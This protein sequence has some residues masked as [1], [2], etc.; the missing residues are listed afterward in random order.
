M[1]DRVMPGP[2]QTAIAAEVKGALS[3]KTMA[4]AVFGRLAG[5]MPHRGQ[6]SGSLICILPSAASGS[7]A[8][9]GRVGAARIGGRRMAGADRP[10]PRS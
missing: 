8:A 3:D 2:Q 7:R 1:R 6:R 9:T 4:A 10:C 5:N